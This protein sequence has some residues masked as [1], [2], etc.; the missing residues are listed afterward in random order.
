MGLGR[1]PPYHGNSNLRRTAATVKS[2]ASFLHWRKPSASDF[3]QAL[4]LLLLASA[5]GVL[6]NLLH[7]SGIELKV[8]GADDALWRAVRADAKTYSGWKDPYGKND[9]PS[10]GE[11][12]TWPAGVERLSLIG[13]KKR[14]DEGSAVFLDARTKAEYEAGHIPGAL[15]FYA[16]EF[17]SY[18]PEVLPQ[19]P[20]DRELVTYCT[21]TSC[22]LSIHLA[23]RLKELGYGNVKVFF[24]GWPEWTKAGYLV[25]EGSAP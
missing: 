13:A 7:P 15:H 21:G 16:E 9:S 22:K 18:A 1:P 6:F 4:D 12:A 20:R 19:L 17:D 14:F 8:K 2:P 3:R 25:R 11:E 5:F 24:G 23:E 10:R